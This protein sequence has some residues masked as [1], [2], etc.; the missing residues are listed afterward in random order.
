MA[1]YDSPM[2]V[3]HTI[4]DAAGLTGVSAHTL[5]YYER[6]GL[7]PPIGRGTGGHRRYTDSDLGA[8][9]FLTMLRATGMPIREMTEFVALTRAGD[10][11]IPWRIEVLERHRDALRFRMADDA[12]HLA[13][14][15]R[16][17]SIYRGLQAEGRKSA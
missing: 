12:E 6:I 16:K 7:L 2:E 4:R 3:S 9:R 14:L 15:D 10:H 8:V 17:I 5:R 13:A 1:E 11:T